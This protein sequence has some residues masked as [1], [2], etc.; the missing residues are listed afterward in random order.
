MAE[1]FKAT[2]LKTVDARASG[3]SNPPP[4]SVSKVPRSGA[5]G[6]PAR[7]VLA[8]SLKVTL[9]FGVLLL[10][11][12]AVL[13][14]SGC[15]FFSCYPYGTVPDFELSD[16]FAGSV[17]A[18]AQFGLPTSVPSNG[19]VFPS[20]G[21]A[22]GHECAQTATCMMT[23]SNCTTTCFDFLVSAGTPESD[24]LSVAFADFD[25]R[26]GQV[27]TL[28]DPRVT[29]RAS[30]STGFET[31]DLTLMATGGSFS[32]RLVGDEMDVAFLARHG[33]ERGRSDLHHER[34]GRGPR[35]K[36]DDVL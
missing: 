14:A 27:L 35:A 4:S 21:S 1:W 28:P 23:P 17:S 19:G 22:S 26:L 30:V 12:P 36:R 16:A 29:L 32:S 5:A 10:A 25:P 11:L 2:V 8:S 20:T 7:R 24:T 3:G 33:H 18:P 6:V 31:P 13:T 9:R 15:D 34:Q